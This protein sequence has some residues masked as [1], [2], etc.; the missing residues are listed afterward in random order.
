MRTGPLITIVVIVIVIVAGLMFWGRGR[1]DN[2]NTG[3]TPTPS[4]TETA[5]PTPTT[6][7]STTSASQSAKTVTV[8]YT[9]QGFTPSTIT[10]N[11]GDIVKFI[12]NSSRSFW[13]ASNDHPTH[14]LYPE[15]DPKQSI[16]AGSSWS[17]KFDKVGTWGYHDHR[18]AVKTGTV[19]VK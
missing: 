8:T 9:D 10:I 12:N 17:F 1:D 7:A 2:R 14:L 11:K 4:Q 3:F 16:A 15:F 5:T 6:P 13:P 19:V 18:S